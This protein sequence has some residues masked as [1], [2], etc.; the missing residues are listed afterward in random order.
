[1]PIKKFDSPIQ[2]EEE[3][4]DEED[5]EEEEEEEEEEKKFDFT[6]DFVKNVFTNCGIRDLS[7]LGSSITDLNDKP[8]DDLNDC[9][10]IVITSPMV[11]GGR[12]AR[13]W[14]HL[15][16]SLLKTHKELNDSGKKFQVVYV[17]LFLCLLTI[18]NTH[19]P[20]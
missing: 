12:V 5:E 10:C 15:H 2:E 17:L 11:I 14:K 1:M 4:E 9:E 19:T 6:K 13:P 8:I 16:K 7:I 20:L 3:E 18:Y